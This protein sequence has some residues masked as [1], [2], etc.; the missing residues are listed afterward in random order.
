MTP[1]SSAHFI[2]VLPRRET[3]PPSRPSAASSETLNGTVREA[4]SS[5]ERRASPWSRSR[6]ILR[7]VRCP[8]E[9]DLGAAHWPP[10]PGLFWS[11][12]PLRLC[13][14][15]GYRPLFDYDEEAAMLS[16]IIRDRARASSD[17]PPPPPPLTRPNAP[18]SAGGRHDFPATPSNS[19]GYRADRSRADRRELRASGSSPRG[20]R[21]GS[22]RSQE[23]RRALSCSAWVSSSICSSSPLARPPMP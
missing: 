21:A 8:E 6:P 10:R 22:D 23:P 4:S 18:P 16:A 3:P 7:F 1:R 13:R 2:L 17:L 14:E 9:L 19:L 12:A 15:Y 11:G 20:L 5:C